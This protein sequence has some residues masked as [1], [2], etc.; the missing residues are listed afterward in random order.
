VAL[1]ADTVA[2]VIMSWL[3]GAQ[4]QFS[5]LLGIGQMAGRAQVLVNG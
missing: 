2:I 1:D 3:P 4:G 5:A